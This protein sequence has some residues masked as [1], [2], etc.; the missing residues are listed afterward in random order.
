MDTLSLSRFILKNTELLSRNFAITIESSRKEFQR[1]YREIDLS[2]WCALVHTRTTFKTSYA[3]WKNRRDSDSHL[4]S[5]SLNFATRRARQNMI[6]PWREAGSSRS[7]GCAGQCPISR[8]PG[9]TLRVYVVVLVEKRLIWLAL[10]LFL[11]CVRAKGRRT[12]E[13]DARR[14]ADG[15]DRMVSKTGVAR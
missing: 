5:S 8:P 7:S 13:E 12:R 6:Y 11:F 1:V 14:I 4:I 15:I 9:Y 10:S 3:K 2:P